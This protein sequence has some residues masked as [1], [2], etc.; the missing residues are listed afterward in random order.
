LAYSTKFP[1]SLLS[2]VSARSHGRPVQAIS[3][4]YL[5]LFPR[6]RSAWYPT[7]S[8]FFFET[9][10]RFLYAGQAFFCGR[11]PYGLDR[12][13]NCCIRRTV[14]YPLLFFVM[15]PLEEII[16][17]FSPGVLFFTENLVSVSPVLIV[18]YAVDAFFAASLWPFPWWCR[19]I[20]IL[21]LF[22]PRSFFLCPQFFRV[23]CARDFRP[24]GFFFS[25]KLV[26]WFPS[27]TGSHFLDLFSFLF[28]TVRSP[29]PAN[30]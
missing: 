13:C 6:G 10:M 3:S 25:P 18:P 20:E 19:R 24:R 1:L 5:S 16:R 30:R 29:L 4:S 26:P 15:F 22:F 8:W 14:S 9:G 21:F 12:F 28:Y 11:V 2:S 7:L 27:T 17:I 23:V